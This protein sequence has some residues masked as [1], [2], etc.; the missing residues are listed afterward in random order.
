M[1]LTQR[2]IN[3]FLPDNIPATTSGTMWQDLPDQMCFLQQLI[4]LPK[5]NTLKRVTIKWRCV[6]SPT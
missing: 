4:S 1:G 5:P 3:E 2:V 6:S